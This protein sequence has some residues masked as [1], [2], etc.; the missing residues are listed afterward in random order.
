METQSLKPT[1]FVALLLTAIAATSSGCAQPVTKNEPLE[2]ASVIAAVPRGADSQ[3]SE[4]LDAITSKCGNNAQLVYLYSISNSYLGGQ[5]IDTYVFTAAA[6][7]SK[8]QLIS[9]LYNRTTGQI[10]IDPQLN[11]NTNQ[12]LRPIPMSDWNVGYDQAVAAASDAV[13]S[14]FLHDHPTAS[15]IVGLSFRQNEPFR[16]EIIFKSP[17]GDSVSLFVDAQAG[18]VSSQ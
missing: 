18:S 16:W 3:Y 2:S 11:D 9:V 10:S 8:G 12:L 1:T 13:R 5:R 15:M 17:Q 7:G 14:T 6:C 4:T